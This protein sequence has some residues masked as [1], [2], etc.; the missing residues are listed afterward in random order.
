MRKRK[1]ISD[2][3]KLDENKIANIMLAVS[4]IRYV[5]L[6]NIQR[7]LG[8]K[9]HLYKKIFNY[10]IDL[11]SI[12]KYAE[13]ADIKRFEYFKEFEN[14]LDQKFLNT[15]KN[16]LTQQEQLSSMELRQ[17]CILLE[18]FMRLNVLH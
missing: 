4:G 11:T 16:K 1:M 2:K 6:V 12:D 5:D 17:L 14:D 8:H 13:T 9:S 10:L 3:T 18:K 15:I 7:D